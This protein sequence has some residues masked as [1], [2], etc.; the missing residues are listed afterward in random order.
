MKLHATHIIKFRKK[1][2]KIK[3][4]IS[5]IIYI[6]IHVLCMQKKQGAQVIGPRCRHRDRDGAVQ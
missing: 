3:L 5:T 4:I 6:R 2:D 1:Y